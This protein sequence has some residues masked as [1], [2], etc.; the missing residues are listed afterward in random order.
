MPHPL[1]LDTWAALNHKLD[2]R[3]RLSQG[4]F[5]APTWVRGHERRLGAYRL[6]AA[7]L[8]NNASHFLDTTDEAVR[9][10]HREYG[11]AA[12]LVAVAKA[13]LLGDDVSIVVEGAG[14]VAA[15]GRKLTAEETAANERQEWLEAWADDERLRAKIDKAEENA[16]GL[17]DAVYALGWSDSKRRV[18]VRRYDP[19][20][21]FPDLDPANADDDFPTRVDVAWEYETFDANDNPERWVRRQTWDLRE[22]PAG[23]RLAVPWETTDPRVDCYLTDGTWKVEDIGGRR[24]SQPWPN[25]QY[26]RNGD[27]IERRDLALGLGFLPVVHVPNTVAEEEHFGRSI[28]LAVAQLLD[29][30]AAGDTDAAK[31]AALACVPMLGVEDEAAGVPG[32]QMS[33]RPGAVFGGKVSA[34]DLGPALAAAM[35]YVAKLLDRLSTNSRIPAEVLGRVKASEV[36]SGLALALAFGPLRSLIEEMR[37]VRAEK[38]PLVLKFAQRIGWKAGV[39]AGGLGSPDLRAEVHFGAFLPSDAPA[40]IEAVTKLWE[41]RLVRRETAIRRLVEEGII[42]T[43]VAEELKGVRSEDF[44]EALKLLDATDGD[45]DAVYE[46]LSRPKPQRDEPTSGGVPATGEPTGD[47]IVPPPARIDLG[48][49]ER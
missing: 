31:A 2:E 7:Y 32:S 45:L 26:R 14:A 8:S 17:G 47:E 25:G 11:D 34:V 12:L 3:G 42:D 30:L 9:S 18:R 27:G 43:D 28:L 15:D 36:P 29:E 4:S 41:A 49:D 21:Y 46:F 35:A 10:D 22:L 38:Y 39:S 19:G 5:V 44:D 1:V 16:V 40:V 23:R 13:A 20:F 37:L 6:L 33:V 48:D 24:V